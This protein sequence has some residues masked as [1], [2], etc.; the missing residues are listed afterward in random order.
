MTF[1][2]SIEFCLGGKGLR[3]GQCSKLEMGGKAT[4]LLAVLKEREKSKQN[5][6][7]H[8]GNIDAHSL[9]SHDR[10]G[11]IN[12]AMSPCDAKAQEIQGGSIQSMT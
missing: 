10:V 9:T 7:T 12:T 4:A 8:H 3:L 11:G 6:A 1:A 5:R 2:A